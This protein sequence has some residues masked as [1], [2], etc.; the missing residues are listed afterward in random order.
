[1][2]IGQ[3]YSVPIFFIWTS[4]TGAL[5][6]SH[7]ALVHLAGPR[8]LQ[9]NGA[10][11]SLTGSDEEIGILPSGLMANLGVRGTQRHLAPRLCD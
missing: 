5:L 10:V 6:Q 2:R 1:M 11:C 8:P 7:R 4:L 9:G 3:T